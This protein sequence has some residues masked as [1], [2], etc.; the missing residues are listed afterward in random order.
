[1]VGSLARR[2]VIE[3]P[4][5]L[6]TSGIDFVARRVQALEPGDAG[7]APIPG[8]QI[9]IR[10]A[11]ASRARLTLRT[12]SPLSGLV[13]L[14]LDEN[15]T[16]AGHHIRYRTRLQRFPAMFWFTWMAV[17]L[18]AL[19]LEIM[20]PEAGSSERVW[21]LGTIAVVAP[22][23]FLISIRRSMREADLILKQLEARFG[24]SA[25]DSDEEVGE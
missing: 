5:S 10:V 8:G 17:L 6:A 19:A 18:G 13:A 25:V 3:V 23:L 12:G 22:V 2:G 9:V 1:M 15:E 11:G 7:T 4:D 16:G 21:L 20:Y 24:T 14:E